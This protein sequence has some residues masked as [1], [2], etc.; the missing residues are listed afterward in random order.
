[1]FWLKMKVLISYEYFANSLVFPVYYSNRSIHY[2]ILVARIIMVF[3]II[4]TSL[5]TFSS[6][7]AIP[8]ITCHKLSRI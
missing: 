6:H 4:P 3:A 1:M 2:V 5:W 8:C 7:N